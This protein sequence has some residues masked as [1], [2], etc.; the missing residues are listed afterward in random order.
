MQN[1]LGQYCPQQTGESHLLIYVRVLSRILSC[2]ASSASWG[3]STADIDNC[4]SRVLCSESIRSAPYRF[5]CSVFI[6]HLLKCFLLHRTSSFAIASFSLSRNPLI[7]TI[8]PIVFQRLIL[9]PMSICRRNALSWTLCQ[10]APHRHL[11]GKPS[12]RTWL[13]ACSNTPA[14]LLSVFP[15]F[16]SPSWDAPPARQ[17]SLQVCA[18]L[19][20]VR[21]VSNTPGAPQPWRIALCG[22]S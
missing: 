9:R 16:Q 22:I 6:T 11:C 10:P 2:P 19:K 17:I 7:K 13:Y 4:R 14:T 12:C 5:V 8:V 21:I 1:L 18:A 20:A 3:H 15:A